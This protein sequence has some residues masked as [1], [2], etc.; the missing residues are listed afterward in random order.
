[1]PICGGFVSPPRA[2]WKAGPLL[3]R[4][5]DLLWEMLKKENFAKCGQDRSGRLAPGLVTA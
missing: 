4:L 3:H 1:V 5:H 2:L